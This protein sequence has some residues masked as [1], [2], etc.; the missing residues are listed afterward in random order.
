M[1]R[2][3]CASATAN[4]ISAESPSRTS[5]RDAGR[6]GVAVHVADED[7]SIAVDARERGELDVG[8][9]RLRAAEAALARALAEAREQG[10]DRLRVPVS[11]RSDR[12]PVEVA[13]L[14][15]TSVNARDGPRLPRDGPSS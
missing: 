12:E 6:L 10:G 8:E 7:V 11:Q 4:A 1:P 3:W 15:V 14:H 2:L 9:P 5:L 13:R